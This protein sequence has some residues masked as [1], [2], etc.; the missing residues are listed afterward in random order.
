MSMP[1]KLL[2]N[3]SDDA[4][5]G[6]RAAPVPESMIEKLCDLFYFLLQVVV[7]L[8]IHSQTSLI[9]NR[10]WCFGTR[11]SNRFSPL[12]TDTKNTIT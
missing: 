6:G 2:N 11:V 12:I 1:T 9:R 5:T 8:V 3:P 7:S 4:L 10:L